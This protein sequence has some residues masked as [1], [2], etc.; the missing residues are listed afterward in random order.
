MIFVDT[1]IF[2]RF[3]IKDEPK[4]AKSSEELFKK[5]RE[6]KKELWTTEWVIAEISWLLTSYYRLPKTKIVEIIKKIISTKGLKTRNQHLV[7]EA[8]GLYLEKNI[9]LEDAI[10]A[11]LAREE[12]IKIV[13]SY[14]KDF[15]KISWLKR[16]EP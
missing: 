2:V 5:A 4:Q 10:N 8:I 6:G 3:F 13:Y 1:N 11:I 15:N 12:K 7:L 9:D 16:K 14:D